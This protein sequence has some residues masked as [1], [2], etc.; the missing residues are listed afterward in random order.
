MGGA[1]RSTREIMEQVE[2][3]PAKVANTDIDKDYWTTPFGEQP[4]AL[5][6][7]VL[8]IT[9]KIGGDVMAESPTC[10]HGHRIWRESK[11]GAP[12]S[13]GGYFCPQ[14]EKANQ[15]DPYW[16]KLSSNGKWAS[17]F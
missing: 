1:E 6:T 12:K 16:Y 10:N 4:T 5:S 3:T 17:Q 7:A 8:E 11:A 9:S 15:C 13:W 2:S 14:K